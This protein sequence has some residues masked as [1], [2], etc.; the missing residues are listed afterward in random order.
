MITEGKAITLL[1]EN[2]YAETMEKTVLPA[3]TKV[4]THGWM[5][6][7]TYPGLK[8]L[9]APAGSHHG[10]LHYVSY[11]HPLA[12]SQNQ[13]LGNDGQGSGPEGSTIEERP[14]IV[15][16]HGFTGIIPHYTELAYYFFQAG[17][18]VWIMEHRGHGLSPHD[19]TDPSVIWIDDWR[20][21]VVDLAKFAQE[22]V[23]PQTSGDLYLFA[24]SMGGGIGISVAQQFPDIFSKI[25]L[26]SPMIEA[27]MAGIPGPVAKRIARAF[28]RAGKG[29]NRVFAQKPFSPVLDPNSIRGLSAA[30]AQWRFDTRLT[31]KRYQTC[32]ASYQW[33]LQTFG[34]K[35][36][37][38]NPANCA[39]I[40]ASIM[41]FQAE[42]DTF[43]RLDRQDEF[44]DMAQAAD[45]DVEKVFIPQAMHDFSE[46]PN[47][48]LA[49]VLEQSIDFLGE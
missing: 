20:R 40:Q 18:D 38:L 26:T 4:C 17:F 37:L 47:H 30:R 32:A 31:D 34:L 3:T 14:S 45:C 42:N 35:K 16:S 11:R 9:P 36:S 8:E 15:I 48:I 29:K 7:A 43:V 12:S 46:G 6:P 49:P 41:L 28:C 39:K 1:D 13:D 24:H 19:V 21:Y 22:V 10:M 25:I 5:N 27:Q 33:V 23:R 2:T 44:I